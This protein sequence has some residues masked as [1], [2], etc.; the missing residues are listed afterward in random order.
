MP[1]TFT[2]SLRR[3]RERPARPGATSAISPSITGDIGPNSRSHP[4]DGSSVSSMPP[5]LEISIDVR[6]DTV[7]SAVSKPRTELALV[8]WMAT[9]IAMPAAMPAMVVRLRAGSPTSRRTTNW[10]KRRLIR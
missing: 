3:G 1:S 8:S 5:G 6:P 4:S 7:S 9:T 10:T 2:A